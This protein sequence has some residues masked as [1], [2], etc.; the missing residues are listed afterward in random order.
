MQLGSLLD[1]RGANQVLLESVPFLRSFLRG[2][3]SL[4]DFHL[5]KSPDMFIA[6]Y[7]AAAAALGWFVPCV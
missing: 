5:S 7:A 2:K 6:E 4:V 1:Y 3:M